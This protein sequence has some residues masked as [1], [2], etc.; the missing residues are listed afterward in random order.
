MSEDGNTNVDSK[1]KIV[2]QEKERG[3]PNFVNFP[4]SRRYNAVVGGLYAIFICIF[5]YLSLIARGRN[6]HII[7]PGR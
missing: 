1:G 2:H 5:F 7:I 4:S 3:G 6:G